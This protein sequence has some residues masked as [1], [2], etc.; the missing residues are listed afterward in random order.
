MIYQNKNYYKYDPIGPHKLIFIRE[1]DHSE[2]N[3]NHKMIEA[4]CHCGNYFDVRTSYVVSGRQKSCGCLNQWCNRKIT[5]DNRPP[6]NCPWF[7][8]TTRSIMA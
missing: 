4:I 2:F 7:A 1:L 6:S 3:S 5:G 8:L